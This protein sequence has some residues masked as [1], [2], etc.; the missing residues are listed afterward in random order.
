MK[1]LDELVQD[2]PRELYDEILRLTFT[3]EP[4]AHLIDKA[5]KPPK[6]LRV[7]RQTREMFAASFYGSS[8]F[9]IPEYINIKHV[10]IS[11]NH[12]A[13]KW[14]DSLPAAHVEL[15][16]NVRIHDD[17]IEYGHRKM[18]R[19]IE[20]ALD[21]FYIDDWILH[22]LLM[23][24]AI[25]LKFRDQTTGRFEFLRIESRSDLEYDRQSPPVLDLAPVGF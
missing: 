9:D 13:R 14:L 22:R 21:L 3:A 18:S 16:K 5:Y 24:H 11:E 19:H 10:Y 12:Y 25:L 4:A 7:S 17:A 15:L 2:L 23:N 20:T 6:R 1:T 8:V